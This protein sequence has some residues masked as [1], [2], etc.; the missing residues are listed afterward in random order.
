ME[1]VPCFW[2]SS[3]WCVAWI[4][5]KLAFP[6]AIAYGIY[7]LALR[8]IATTRQANLDQLERKRQI[9]FADKQLTEFYAPMVGARAEIFNRRVF[10]TYVVRAVRFVEAEWEKR[11]DDGRTAVEKHDL[12][13]EPAYSA[14][15]K[16]LRQERVNGY[17]AMRDLFASKMAFADPETRGWF[18]YFYAFVEMLRVAQDN[19]EKKFLSPEVSIAMTGMFE[20]KPLQPFYQYLLERTDQLQRGIQGA[21][22]EA[23]IQVPKPPEVPEPWLLFQ[24]SR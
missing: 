16:A 6:L 12:K 5:E 23:V 17:L 20:E 9:D 11:Y 13:L 15:D 4:V 24:Q 3:P 2:E 8:Q 7:R 22:S 19:E 18:D 1:I 14:M 21:P 10:E